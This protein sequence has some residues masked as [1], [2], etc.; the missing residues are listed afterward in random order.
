MVQRRLPI[1][2]QILAQVHVEQADMA[3]DKMSEIR[4]LP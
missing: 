1:E 4:H 3:A 2:C